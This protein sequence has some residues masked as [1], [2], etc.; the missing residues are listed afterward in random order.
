MARE[1]QSYSNVEVLEAVPFLWAKRF[2]NMRIHCEIS[3]A[4]EV[5]AT[6]DILLC[7]H[8]RFKYTICGLTNCFIFNIQSKRYSYFYVELDH[9][10]YI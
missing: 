1:L 9:F 7:Q 2:T 6:T 10:M 8:R 5:H 3:A 4:Y